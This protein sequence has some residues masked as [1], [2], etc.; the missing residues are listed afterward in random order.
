M[1][2]FSTICLI[3]CYNVLYLKEDFESINT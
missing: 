3:I 1:C 2:V